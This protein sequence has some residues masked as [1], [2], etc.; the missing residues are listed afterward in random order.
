MK[1]DFKRKTAVDGHKVLIKNGVAVGDFKI[2]DDP[3]TI[4][5]I[6]ELYAVYKTSVPNGIRYKRPYF[7]ALSA[8]QLTTQ[9]LIAGANRQEAKDKLELTVLIGILNGSLVWPDQTKWFWQ[10]EKDKDLILLRDWFV[11]ERKENVE[12]PSYAVQ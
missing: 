3:V 1:I 10:S 12:Q 8:D 6:E 11:P 2:P 9:N 4:E 7:R 5:Q